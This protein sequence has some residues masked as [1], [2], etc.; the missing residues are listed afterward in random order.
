MYGLLDARCAR[1]S[2]TPVYICASAR[3]P[4]GP[5][6]GPPARWVEDQGRGGEV[7]SLLLI[8]AMK[9][10]AGRAGQTQA[11]SSPGWPDG[12]GVMMS[13]AA[14]SRAEGTQVWRNDDGRRRHPMKRTVIMVMLCAALA[15]PM[16][17]SPGDQTIPPEAQ[18]TPTPAT[19]ST[20][21]GN[22]MASVL[23]DTGV[24]ERRSPVQATPAEASHDPGPATRMTRRKTAMCMTCTSTIVPKGR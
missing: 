23:V 2:L 7:A 20:G 15:T 4:I 5:C 21:D 13:G 1:L 24:I 18:W 19:R 16:V 3:L 17:G 12:T 9:P 10:A 22:Q 14:R 6:H 11:P 8:Q